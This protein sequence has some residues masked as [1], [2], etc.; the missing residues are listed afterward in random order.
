MTLPEQY[1]PSA[2]SNRCAQIRSGDVCLRFLATD[3]AA[4]IIARHAV[5]FG[6]WILNRNHRAPGTTTHRHIRTR[7]RTIQRPY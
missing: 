6:V 2:L 5:P 7:L 3:T 1:T 4:S